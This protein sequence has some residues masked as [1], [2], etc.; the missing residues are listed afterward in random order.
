[1]SLVQDGHPLN[2]DYLQKYFR[3]VFQLFIQKNTAI[4]F[5]TPPDIEY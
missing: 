3:K 4:S 5:L 1:M 2:K